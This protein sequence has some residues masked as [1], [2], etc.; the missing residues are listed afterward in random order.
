MLAWLLGMC[1]GLLPY[2]GPSLG[3]SGLATVQP[4]AVLAFATAFLVR[5]VLGMFGMDSAEVEDEST[6]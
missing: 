4:A 2:L 5:V 1:V 6:A 3:V